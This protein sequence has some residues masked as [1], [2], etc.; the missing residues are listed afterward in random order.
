MKKTAFILTLLSLIPTIITS[1]SASG[2]RFSFTNPSFNNNA[3]TSAHLLALAESQKQHKK[4][5][6]QLSAVEEFSERLETQLL[7]N[8]VGEVVNAINDDSIPSEGSD[9][10][11]GEL[12]IN[13]IPLGDGAFRITVT[14][15]IQS[16]FIDFG[17]N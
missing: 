17:G 2:L 15:G 16:S 12:D 11:A 5:E 9:F 7:S 14:D 6:P 3:F 8:A 4:S 1:G 10:N 13:V